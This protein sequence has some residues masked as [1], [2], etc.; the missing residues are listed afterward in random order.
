[1]RRTFVLALFLASA[2]SGQ[3]L[4]PEGKAWLS[5]YKEPAEVN[6]NGKWHAGEWGL[7]T[8]NQAAGS[9]EVTGN[10]SG[11]GLDILGVVNATKV[12]LVF[13]R[14]GNVR[15]S[16]EVSPEGPNVLAGQYADALAWKSGTRIMHLTRADVQEH[17]SVESEGAQAHVVFYRVHRLMGRFIKPAVYCDD[18]EA[19]FMYG[20]H[21]FTAALSPGKHSLASDDQYTSVS[22]DAEA[23][24]TYY[25]R[26]ALSRSEPMRATFKVEQ[27]DSD[28]AANDLKR[29]K[30]AEAS[31][32]TRRDIVSAELPAK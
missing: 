19:A 16:I 8:L 17:P 15:Y 26:V 29:L 12:L 4:E 7:I 27:V 28:T 13:S 6:V 22:L 3:K 24:Q 18:Q 20:G 23:G 32:I 2:L 30:P 25:V 21:Y 1:M 5:S 10:A 9:R 11:D 31:H 14:S